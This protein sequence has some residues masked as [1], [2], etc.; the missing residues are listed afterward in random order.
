MAIS[1]DTLTNHSRRFSASENIYK[2]SQRSR[3]AFL[4]HSHLDAQYVKGFI[5]LLK[6][7]NIAA[8]SMTINVEIPVSEDILVVV[9]RN[10]DSELLEI[11]PNIEDVFMKLMQE[12]AI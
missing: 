4:C 9:N 6:E 10:E 7:E 1:L 3:K 5:Q 2:S 8:E 11:N 12:S